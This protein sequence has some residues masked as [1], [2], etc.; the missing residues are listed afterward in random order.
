MTRYSIFNDPILGGITQSHTHDPYKR[1]P[2]LRQRNRPPPNH[3]MT[4]DTYYTPP[5]RALYTPP[6][7]EED[8]EKDYEILQESLLPNF[9]SDFWTNVNWRDLVKDKL[10][11]LNCDI[12]FNVVPPDDFIDQLINEPELPDNLE[13]IFIKD[14]HPTEYLNEPLEIEI[15]KSSERNITF[16]VDYDLEDKY[17]DKLGDMI[18]ELD[19]FIKQEIDYLE[20]L[21]EKEK[22]KPPEVEIKD[23]NPYIE[24]VEEP[25]QISIAN[26]DGI[27]ISDLPLGYSSTELNMDE[28]EILSL[29]DDYDYGENRTVK[30]HSDVELHRYPTQPNDGYYYDG[31]DGGDNHILGN[32]YQYDG[33]YYDKYGSEYTS[34]YGGLTSVMNW[35]Y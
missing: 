20:Y 33:K 6:K 19:D 17:T 4:H 15:S 30:F 2:V 22:N 3:R 23:E 35:I 27:Q 12:T 25:M 10:K 28:Y 8:I 24:S 18:N 29:S 9:L 7:R 14:C 26:G 11:E 32:K 5:H 31:N 13:P 16:K 21:K 34:S 1:H